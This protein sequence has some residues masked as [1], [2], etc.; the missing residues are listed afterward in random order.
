MICDLCLKK[1]LFQDILILIELADTG[2]SNLDIEI[3]R[4]EENSI[5]L[6]QCTMYIPFCNKT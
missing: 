1:I 3:G 4:A 6:V 5:I 2:K